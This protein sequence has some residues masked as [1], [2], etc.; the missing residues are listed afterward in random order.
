MM[1]LHPQATWRYIQFMAFPGTAIVLSP[2]TIEMYREV[3]LFS[4]SLIDNFQEGEQILV[5]L[6]QT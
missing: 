6:P 3:S 1:N 4:T 2:L 5:S